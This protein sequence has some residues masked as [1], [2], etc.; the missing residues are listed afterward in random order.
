[1]LT[2]GEFHLP[3]L[4][5]CIVNAGVRVVNRQQRLAPLPCQGVDGGCFLVRD[6]GLP[7]NQ[8]VKQRG[9]VVV[10]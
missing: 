10:P 3:K 8:V 6:W 4:D 9:R 5:D 7:S 1:M 2:R